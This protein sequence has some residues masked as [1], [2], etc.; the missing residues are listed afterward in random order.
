MRKVPDKS[1]LG[2][3][4]KISPQNSQGHWRQGKSGNCHNLKESKRDN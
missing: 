4:Y 3:F 2:A 1:Q